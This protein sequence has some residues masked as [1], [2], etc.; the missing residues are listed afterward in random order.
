MTHSHPN[1]P[2]YELTLEMIL[3][4]LVEQYGWGE[5]G[6]RIEIKCFKK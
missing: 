5:M 1:N 4:C 6:Q 2:P 3:I